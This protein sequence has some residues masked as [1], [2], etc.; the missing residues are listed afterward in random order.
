MA[1][2]LTGDSNNNNGWIGATDSSSE[3]TW[4]WSDGSTWSYTNWWVTNGGVTQP[5]GGSSQNC[6]QMRW[7]DYMWDDISCTGSKE[8][9]V[10]KK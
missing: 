5:A 4:T 2:V 3:G 6:A 10:C 1:S 9:Y 8:F 7:S